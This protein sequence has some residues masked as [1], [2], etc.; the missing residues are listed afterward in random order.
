MMCERLKKGK[1][2]RK[3]RELIADFCW[4]TL[5]AETVFEEPGQGG[6]EKRKE[7]KDSHPG[8][9]HHFHLSARPC[10]DW[11]RATGGEGEGKGEKNVV[12][13]HAGVR[14]PEIAVHRYALALNAS[15]SLGKR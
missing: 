11:T 13:L 14:R 9:V 15:K 12:A 6:R 3:K 7:K 5:L 8:I 1:G 4:Q 10:A 2:K